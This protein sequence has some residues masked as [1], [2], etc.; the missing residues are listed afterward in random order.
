M[1]VYAVIWESHDGYDLERLF[2][3]RRSADLYVANRVYAV[4]DLS[5]PGLQPVWI[6]ECNGHEIGYAAT[7]ASALRIVEKHRETGYGA[8]SYAVTCREVLP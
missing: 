6:A 3:S 2:V 8:G 1:N 7:E 5:S 4:R